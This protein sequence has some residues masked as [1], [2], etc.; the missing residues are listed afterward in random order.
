[1]ADLTSS[2]GRA[3]GNAQRYAQKVAGDWVVPLA[4]MGY[5]AKGIV[6]VIV[7]V[8]AVQAAFGTGGQTTGSEGAIRSIA[9]EPFGQIL[10]GLMALGLFAY[11]VWRFA[12]AVLDAE[13]YGT[14]AKAIV[15]RLFYAISGLIYGSLSILAARMALGMGSSGEGD[16]RQSMT[17]DLMSQPFG[18]V[19]VGLVGGL[20]I[21][22]GLYQLYKAYKKDFM[23]SYEVEAMSGAERKLARR[24]GQW[25][26][27]A[28]GI[29]FGIIGWFFI[30]AA[31]QQDPSEARGL[32]AALSTLAQQP[33]GTWLLAVVAAG[34]VAYGIHCFVKA[35]YRHFET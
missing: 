28:R 25:G 23:D 27:G 33:Y 19:L 14:D 18:P 9:D 21:A 17:A 20:I 3:P 16:A 35:R 22:V 11:V 5:I 6:Y 12:Q 26:L 4:R 32:D 31:M 29:V 24:V 34:L 13:A 10:L 2:L 15:R 8:L 1:M 7:G 30:R